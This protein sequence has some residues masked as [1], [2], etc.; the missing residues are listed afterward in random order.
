[1]PCDEVGK[2][3]TEKTNINEQKLDLPEGVPALTSLYLYIAGSCNL[4]CRHCWITPTF[5]ASGNGGQFIKLE[6]VEKAVREAKPLGLRSVKLTG[7]EP[8]LH[9]QFREIVEIIHEQGIEIILETNGTLVDADL[10]QFLMQQQ[11]GFISVSLDGATAETHEALRLVPG[12]FDQAVSGIKFLVEAGF[13]PQLIC[14]LNRGNIT[15][16]EQIM[17]LAEEL[18]CGSVKFNVLQKIGRGEK[19]SMEAGLA[20]SEVIRWHEYVNNQIPTNGIVKLYFD[21]PMAFFPIRKLLSDLSFCNMSHVL[22]M[23]AG[24]ELSLCGIGVSEKDL[25]YGN[26]DIDK[27]RKV[28][29]DSPGLSKLRNLVPAQLEGICNECLHRDICNGSCIA[30]NYYSSGKLN[31]ASVFCEAAN[32]AGLFPLSRKKSIIKS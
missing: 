31:A 30:N 15:E 8:T 2:I 14:T 4:A 19:L 1:M 28:W 29:C 12:S 7:G 27:L 16:I 18:G 11:V 20:V 21:I 23:L 5:Q 25:V 13:R 24:G 3:I 26:I 6:Y 10:A 9:P 32:I 22:G 17:D